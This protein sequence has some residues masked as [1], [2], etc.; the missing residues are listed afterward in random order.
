MKKIVLLAFVIA[1]VAA[2]CSTQRGMYHQSFPN[3]KNSGC[4]S[5]KG[6]VGF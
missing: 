1:L 4:P 6:M 5:T 2:S 3:D